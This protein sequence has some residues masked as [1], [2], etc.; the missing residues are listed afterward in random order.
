[1]KYIT[2]LILIT[3]YL[4]S[5]P[6]FNKLRAFKDADGSIFY[7]RAQG[8][9]YLNWIETQDG[10]ILKYNIK[11]K[12]FEYA[13]IEGNQLKASGTNYKLKEK[14][15]IKRVDKSRLYKLWNNKSLKSKKCISTK[16]Q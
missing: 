12:H 1:M 16:L 15:T 2:I 13:K 5:A 11:S 7:A 4:L 6:A 9:Q 3:T 14:I 8:D 10:T